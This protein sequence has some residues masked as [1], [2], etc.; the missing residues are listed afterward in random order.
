MEQFSYIV[1]LEPG[2]WISSG[3]GD[4]ERTLVKDHARRF[5]AKRDA[6]SAIRRARLH[7]PFVHAKAIKTNFAPHDC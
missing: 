4:V 6:L 7:K 3:H 5:V 1:E 2:V